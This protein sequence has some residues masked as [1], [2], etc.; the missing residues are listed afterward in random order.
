MKLTKS[1]QR[2][3][4]VLARRESQRHKVYVYEIEDAIWMASQQMPS[5]GTVQKALDSLVSKGL[6]DGYSCFSATPRGIEYASTLKRDVV[7]S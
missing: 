3:L 7:F 4:Y 6:V 2:V 1:Q 5:A